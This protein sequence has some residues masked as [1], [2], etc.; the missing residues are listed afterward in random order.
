MTTDSDN[1]KQ[2]TSSIAESTSAPFPDEVTS[3]ADP[4]KPRKKLNFGLDRFSGLY[5][6]AGA[7]VLHV[8]RQSTAA[9]QC[10]TSPS[11][12]RASRVAAELALA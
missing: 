6:W 1:T 9:R 4:E 5:V 3:G 8:Q 2:Q 11:R 7:I 10:K 12:R